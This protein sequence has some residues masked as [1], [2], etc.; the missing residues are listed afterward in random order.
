MEYAPNRVFMILF[1]FLLKFNIYTRLGINV[2]LM[3]I[4]LSLFSNT[5]TLLLITKGGE[6]LRFWQISHIF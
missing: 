4:T 5:I 3:S 1:D 2:V 6:K